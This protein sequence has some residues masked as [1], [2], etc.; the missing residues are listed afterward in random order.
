MRLTGGADASRKPFA[1]GADGRVFSPVLGGLCHKRIGAGALSCASALLLAGCILV[2]KPLTTEER[3]SEVQVDRQAMFADMEP[4]TRPLTLNDAFARALKYNLDKRVKVM[5]E[6]LAT[7]DLDL[8][9]YDLLPKLSVD[10]LGTTRNRFDASSSESILTRQQSLV[11]STSSD[12]NRFTG[13]LTLSWNILDF[14]VS[15][16]N[17]RQQSNRVLIAQEQ[18]RKAVQTLLQDVRRA[19]WRAAAAQSLDAEVKQ[20]IRVAEATLPAARRVETEGLKSPVDSLRYQKALLDA[21]RQLET[22][23]QALAVSKDELASLINLPPGQPYTVAVPDLNSL[24]A[25]PLSMRVAEMENTA[26]LLNPDIRAESYESRISADETRK[27]LLKLLPGV[28]LSFDPNYDSN[29]FTV[30]HYWLAGAARVNGYLSNLLTAPVVI[31]RTEYEERLAA[32]KRQ[33]MSMAV[34]AKLYISYQQY[35]DSTKYFSRAKELLSVDDRLYRQIAN[36]TAIDVQGDL[37]RILAQASAVDSKL[38]LFQ[39]YAEAQA[40]LARLYETLGI[41]LLHE[42]V[43]TLNVAEVSNAIRQ[44]SVDLSGEATSLTVAQFQE[45]SLQ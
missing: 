7:N 24:R 11:P 41:D 37:E 19:F 40:A 23:Q 29:S 30:H 18:Y 1:R 15:Y 21:I 25:D 20:A 43:G 14:G 32:L 31:P 38:R 5:E 33:A 13:D 2:P 39:C 42:E 10:G 6:A 8:S 9:R 17:A 22:N 44:T 12:I 36:R 3:R 4:L 16:F 28:T 35:Y 27:A 45:L 26:L 34:L